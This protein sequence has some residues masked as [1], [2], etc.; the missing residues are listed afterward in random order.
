MDQGQPKQ[1]S[2]CVK[3]CTSAIRCVGCILI[4]PFMLVG[5]LLF[6]TLFAGPLVYYR[7]TILNSDALAENYSKNGVRLQG[8]VIARWKDS[9]GEGEPTFHVRIVYE[10][11]HERYVKNDLTVNQDLYSKS[12]QDLILLPDYPRSA[13][14]F[15]GVDGS[16]HD[17]P[18]SKLPAIY[19]GFFWMSL[20]NW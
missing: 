20:W 11:D 19:F 3:Y 1:Q 6:G 7:G 16:D 9:G 15:A 12:K 10:V 8:K 5:T 18:P 2:N 14:L 4:C 17:F 13:I